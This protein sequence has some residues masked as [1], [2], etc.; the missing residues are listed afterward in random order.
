MAQVLKQISF[1]MAM[2][3]LLVAL[4]SPLGALPAFQIGYWNLVDS[5]FL[6]ILISGILAASSLLIQIFVSREERPW[7]PRSAIFLFLLAC[8]GVLASIQADK[9]MVALVGT[10]QSGYGPVWHLLAA[11]MVVVVCDLKRHPWALKIIGIVATAIALILSSILAY[12]LVIGQAILIPGSDS[13]GLIGFLMLFFPDD[14]RG[15]RKWAQVQFYALR[16]SAVLLILLSQNMT[17]VAVLVM[18]LFF[19]GG[20]WLASCSRPK[21]VMALQRVP[22]WGMVAWVTIVA[23]GPLGLIMSGVTDAAGPF[24]LSM[25]SVVDAGGASLRMRAI[26]ADIMSAAIQASSWGELIFGHGWGHTQGAFFQFLHWGNMVLYTQAWDFLW[27]DIFHSHNFVLETQY[28]VGIVGLAC[29]VGFLSSIYIGAPRPRRIAALAFVTGYILYSSVWFDLSFHLPYMALALASFAKPHLIFEQ[30][31]NI[32]IVQ[33]RRIASVKRMLI[34]LCA[35]TVLAL[36]VLTFTYAEFSTQMTVLKPDKGSLENGA[37]L[38]ASVPGDPRQTAFVRSMLYRDV[39][40]HLE[41]YP[42]LH[43]A[44]GVSVLE[45]LVQDVDQRSSVNRSPELVL[46]GLDIFNNIAFLPEWAWAASVVDGKDNIWKKFA[47]RSL[48]VAPYRSDVLIPRLTHLLSTRQFKELGVFVRRI[49]AKKPDDPIAMYYL[50]AIQSQSTDA[51]IKQS[52]LSSIAAALDC[53]IERFVEIPD[54]LVDS[55]QS[56]RDEHQV[57]S[58]KAR[59]W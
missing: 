14:D 42:N 56:Y 17:L 58:V 50:G 49:Q 35:A 48:D 29:L 36:S 47:E 26:I 22:H 18:G 32:S 13:Y 7:V 41:Q 1:V 6:A 51:R 30:F 27:R 24:G 52:G 40:R 23:A 43:N 4:S 28:S 21:I 31:R 8:V 12:S 53:G 38:T 9:P 46:V 54:W 33:S 45:D 11:L 15:N 59:V 19:L 39:L 2:T 34:F 16:A 20:G 55:V 57:C 10:Y 44:K 3:A 37:F 5:S 25:S